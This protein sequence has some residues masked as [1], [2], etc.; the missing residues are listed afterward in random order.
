MATATNKTTAATEIPELAQKARE[1]LLSTVQQ[2]QQ[3]SIDAAQAWVK[4]VS[5]LSIPELPGVPAGPDVEALTKYAFDVAADL[6]SAQRDFTQQLA[7]VLV[8]AKA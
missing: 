2:S 6:L 1:Q 8:P 4:A 3:L 5:A 7:G